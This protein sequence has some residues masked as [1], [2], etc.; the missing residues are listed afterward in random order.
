MRPRSFFV[1]C[2]QLDSTVG[3][4]A[5]LSQFV[6]GKKALVAFFY[7]RVRHELQCGLF[8]LPCE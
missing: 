7:P 4:Q 1:V 5:S 2:R 6:S 3:G 8:K